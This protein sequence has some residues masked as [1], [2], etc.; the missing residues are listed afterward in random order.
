MTTLGL[1]HTSIILVLFLIKHLNLDVLIRN[2]KIE[3]I[4]II[5]FISDCFYLWILNKHAK[6]EDEP[7][8]SKYQMTRNWNS[9][10]NTEDY[11]H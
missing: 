11:A 8:L 4:D 6:R 9:K 5:A 2:K 3:G 1:Q 7:K 10:N